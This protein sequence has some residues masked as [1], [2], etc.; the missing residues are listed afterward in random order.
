MARYRGSEKQPTCSYVRWMPSRRDSVAEAVALSRQAID[1]HAPLVVVMGEARSGKTT[2]CRELAGGLDRRAFIAQVRH[3]RVSHEELLKGILLDFE[4]ISQEEARTDEMSRVS[5]PHLLAVLSGFLGGLRQLG[6]S[7]VLIV[8]EAHGLSPRAE[9][10]R[11]AVE[12]RSLRRD[13][14]SGCARRRA[15]A[16]M[17]A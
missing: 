3:P 10:D 7:A 5:R 11:Q 8:D 14:A 12:R 6:A 4:V 1:R 15:A 13:A 17:A 9:R 2:L 16:E